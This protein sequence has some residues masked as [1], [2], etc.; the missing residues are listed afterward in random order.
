MNEVSLLRGLCALGDLATHEPA[1][2]QTQEEREHQFAII[3]HFQFL[4]HR[5]NNETCLGTVPY[6]QRIFLLKKL[7]DDWEESSWGVLSVFSAVGCDF[8]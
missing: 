8:G 4:S 3:F 1:N 2:H 5:L 6:G 7:M